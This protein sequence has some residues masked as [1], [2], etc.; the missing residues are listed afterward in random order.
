MYVETLKYKM[1]RVFAW[2][3]LN[4]TSVNLLHITVF[5]KVSKLLQ[6]RYSVKISV[7]FPFGFTFLIGL[8]KKNMISTW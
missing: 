1:R 3:H 4:V 8:T 7:H 5:I 6:Q 2:L